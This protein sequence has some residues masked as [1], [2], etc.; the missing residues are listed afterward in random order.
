MP[1]AFERIPGRAPAGFI[2]DVFAGKNIHRP[3]I[4]LSGPWEF[5]RDPEGKGK[6]KGWHLGKGDPSGNITIPGAPQAQGYG[7][8]HVRQKNYFTGPFWIRRTFSFPQPAEGRVVWLRIG[9]IQPAGEVYL[10]GSYVGYTKSSRTPQRIDVTDFLR[11]GAENLVALKICD[12]PEVRLDGLWEMEGLATM[13]TGVYRTVGLEIT[14]SPCLVDAYLLPDLDGSRVRVEVGLSS[15]APAHMRLTLRARDCE[16]VLGKAEAIVDMGKKKAAIDVKLDGFTTWSP[17]HPKLYTMDI[18]L[19]SG[20]EV[21]DEIQVRFG[22][23][24]IATEGGKFYLNGK[25][26]LMRL[27]GDDHLYPD[28]LCPPADKDWYLPRLRLARSYGMNG[29]KSCVD[30]LPEEYMEAADEVGMMVIQE[31][32][33]GLSGLRDNRHTIDQRFRDYYKAEL[34]GLV[35]VTRNHASVISYSM[36]SELSFD[37]QTQESFEFFSRDLVLIA[38]QLAPHALVVDCTGYSIGDLDETPKG[39]RQTDYY[40]FFLPTWKDVLDEPSTASDGVRPRILHEYYWWGCYPDPKDKAKYAGTQMKPFWLD[41]LERTARQNGQ[42]ELIPTYRKNS[43]RLQAMCRKDGIEYVRRNPNLEGYILWLLIDLGQWSEGLLDDFWNPKNVSAEDFL[44]SNGDTVVV[45]AKEGDRCLRMGERHQIPLAVDHY[46]QEILGGCSLS[47]RISE[48]VEGE[49]RLPDLVP[50][51]LTQA[52]FVEFDLVNGRQARK[53]SLRVELRHGPRV[54]NTNEWSFWAF[55]EVP[56]WLLGAATDGKA[57]DLGDGVFLRAGPSSLA[58][59]AKGVSLVIADR[60]DAGLADY[61]ENGGRCVLFTRGAV[62]ENSVRPPSPGNLYRLFRTIPWNVGDYGNSGTVI[63]CHPALKG[64]PHEGV[65]DLQFI[66][67]LKG[68]L[69]MEF[70][71]LREDGVQP[72]IRGIDHYMANR[73]NAHMLEFRVGKGGVLVSSLGVLEELPNHIEA[74]HL[75]LCMLEYAR[76]EEFRPEGAVSRDKFLRLFSPRHG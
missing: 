20:S 5:D 48:G 72:I 22:M 65:C 37:R 2:P 7:E 41:T 28:T 24:E 49:I 3:S 26:V 46:G 30:V 23:R 51:R 25:P 10:N 16:K 71:V 45:L 61:V 42:E 54:I 17:D 6:E 27:F 59:L 31:M 35:R 62:I 57:G 39:K 32:P 44:R 43:L 64:F 47:W 9:G 53:L 68:R 75:L 60:V 69:P 11:P 36:S 15:A 4:D 52:G 34:K 13:W 58:P 40:C 63:A 67:M 1:V 14:G 56:E 8:P 73:N 74:R 66:S 33:F 21:L 18:L 12:L 29:V 55:P 19:C 38:K 50:G 70:S 76:G